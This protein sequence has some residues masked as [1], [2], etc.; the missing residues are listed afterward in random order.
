MAEFI[1]QTFNGLTLAG[2]VSL[3]S[4]GFTLIF[5][6]MRVTNL[7]HD[8]VYLPGGY[9]AYS[10][11]GGHSGN[12]FYGLAAGTFSMAALGVPIERG[13][14]PWLR[15]AEMAE[16]MARWTWCSSSTTSPWRSGAATR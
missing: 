11:I 12:I 5:G 8:A 13:L 15:H 1:V 9:V 14:L 7:A 3:V 4:S 2:I 6:V 10:V 16:L